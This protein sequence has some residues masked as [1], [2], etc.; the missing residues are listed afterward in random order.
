MKLGFK[1]KNKQNERYQISAL[2]LHSPSFAFPFLITLSYICIHAVWERIDY[3]KNAFD[4]SSLVQQL[5]LALHYF[6]TTFFY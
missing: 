2:R 3:I 4:S 5:L 1:F 6:I